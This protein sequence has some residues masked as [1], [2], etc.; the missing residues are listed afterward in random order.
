MYT[1]VW[2]SYVCNVC[3]S[4]QESYK[5]SCIHIKNH[6]SIVLYSCLLNENAFRT[7]LVL[8]IVELFCVFLHKYDKIKAVYINFFYKNYF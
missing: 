4:M 7:K 2:T 6:V 5:L 3:S 1:L 8:I